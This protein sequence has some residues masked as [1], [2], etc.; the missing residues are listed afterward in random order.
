MVVIKLFVVDFVE[1]VFFL[2]DKVVLFVFCCLWLF[3]LIFFLIWFFFCVKGK[4]G[5]KILDCV[6]FFCSFWIFLV[7]LF[8]FEFG[9]MF[10]KYL[11]ESFFSFGFWSWFVIEFLL[12]KW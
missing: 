6:G 12:I 5:I 2:E 3:K 11:F 1:M 9:F 10:D 4:L 7:I 8:S